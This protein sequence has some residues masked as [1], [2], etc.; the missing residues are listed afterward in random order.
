MSNFKKITIA[1]ICFAT[2]AV[3]VLSFMSPIRDYDFWWHLE[4]GKWIWQHK[5]LPSEDPFSY[6]NSKSPSLRTKT[7]LQSY[8]LSELLLYGVYA[9]GGYTGVILFRAVMFLLVLII[10]ARYLQIKKIDELL[11]LTLTLLVLIFLKEFINTRAKLFSYVFSVLVFAL[12]EHYRENRKVSTVLALSVVLLLWANM[13]RGY[14]LAIVILF[15]YALG[16]WIGYVRSR[17]FIKPAIALSLLPFVCLINPLGL[18]SIKQFLYFYGSGLHKESFEFQSPLVVFNH[19]GAG[20]LV[21]LLFLVGVIFFILF[22]YQQLPLAHKLIVVLL[23]VSSLVSL[24]FGIY[25]VTISAMVIAPLLQPV[26]TKKI[27]YIFGTVTVALG[28]IVVLTLPDI[29]YS[30][31]YGYD[32]TVFPEK[33]VQ[34]IKENHLPKPMLNDVV[35]GGYMIHTLYPEYK[36]FVDTRTIEPRVYAQYLAL[37]NGDNS[38]FFD[39]PFWR[40]LI[41]AYDIR[42][43]VHSAVNPYTCKPYPLIKLLMDDPAWKFIYAD[44]TAV[45]FARF[46]EQP[47]QQ[48]PAEYLQRQI[49]LESSRCK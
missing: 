34:F 40:A 24:R 48:L 20:W 22:R 16:E 12:A 11:I 41:Q 37:I 32:R 2:V 21:Y 46:L 31:K 28:L 8:W 36:V 19:L 49:L 27:K 6:T 39:M 47:I 4:T 23:A 42:T 14:I 9:S 1:I 29:G 33:A 30:L 7:I 13:H 18:Y 25:F 38:E 5:G 26:L 45:I 35:W 44:G 15:S 17:N 43:V 3:A 10:I